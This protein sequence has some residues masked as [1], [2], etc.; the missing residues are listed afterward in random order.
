MWGAFIA[1]LNA[2]AKNDEEEAIAVQTAND[3]FNHFAAVFAEADQ[4]VN[5]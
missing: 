5:G 1:V 2:S 4:P 3:T